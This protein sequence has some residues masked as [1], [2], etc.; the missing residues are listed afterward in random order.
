MPAT[1][2]VVFRYYRRFQNMFDSTVHFNVANIFSALR[3]RGVADPTVAVLASSNDLVAE[4]S[5]VLSQAHRFGPT[6]VQ[7]VDHDVAWDAELS[8]TA[9]IAVAAALEY[10]SSPTSE[11]QHA[12]LIRVADYWLVKQ[13]WT[14]QHG[15]RGHDT[16]EVRAARFLKGA[17]R[18]GQGQ[19]LGRGVCKTLIDAATALGALSGDPIADWRLVRSLFTNHNDLGEVFRQVRMVRLF[20]A[21]DA[22]AAALSALWIRRSNYR[23]AAQSVRRVLDQERLVG[24][25]REPRG[26]VLMTLHKSKGKEFDGVV[27]V[28]GFRGGTLLRPDEA[29]D[30]QGSRRLLRVGITRARK[31]AILVRPQ[32]AQS[33]VG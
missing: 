2:D 28:E 8:A 18:I 11:S 30:Y 19:P 4:I 9:A 20:R 22:M 21:T 1:G 31:L 23:G 32:G 33:L 3:Q 7:P 14:T 12:L 24:A 16:A 6:V 26:C 15:G 13:D 27:I 25:E 5:D 17:D 29:P 10:V